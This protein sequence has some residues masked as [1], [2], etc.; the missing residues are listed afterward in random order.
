MIWSH[1]KLLSLLDGHISDRLETTVEAFVHKYVEEETHLVHI[2]FID[3]VQVHAMLYSV[4]D[5]I[6]VSQWVTI[7]S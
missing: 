6:C 1:Y 3:E 7:P 5:I 2:F 4:D